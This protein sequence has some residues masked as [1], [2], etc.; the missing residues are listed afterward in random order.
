MTARSQTDRQTDSQIEVE[1]Q[2]KAERKLGIH[3]QSS[4]INEDQHKDDEIIFRWL[5]E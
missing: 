1:R 4:Q 5:S 2:I 3:K